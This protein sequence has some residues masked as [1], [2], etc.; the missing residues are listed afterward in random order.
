MDTPTLF[1][2]LLN[3]LVKRITPLVIEAVKA[4][5]NTAV[6]AN[7][8]LEPETFRNL[9][10]EAFINDDPLRESVRDMIGEAIDRYDLDDNN[11]FSTLES[12]VSELEDN[13]GTSIDADD[14]DFADAVRSVIRNNI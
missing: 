11:T 6:V 10:R 5:V 7:N 13:G 1:D 14:E 12:R 8:A 9:V 2:A 4:E 3:D